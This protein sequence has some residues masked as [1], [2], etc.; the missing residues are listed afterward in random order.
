M[1]TLWA[2]PLIKLSL[3]FCSRINGEIIYLT[4][5]ENEI[6]SFLRY[7]YYLLS[8]ITQ[9]EAIQRRKAKAE[10]ALVL[11]QIRLLL[12][13]TVIDETEAEA[14]LEKWGRSFNFQTLNST[15]LPLLQLHAPT[16]RWANS[17]EPSQIG[18]SFDAMDVEKCGKF[19]D[20][21]H[22][23]PWRCLV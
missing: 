4:A 8:R 18:L 15:F 20:K 12:L 23:C 3:L 6:S 21:S 11:N 9:L 2:Q 7:D 1:N 10:R 22:C 16:W 19:L 17:F 13:L 14:D 5:M